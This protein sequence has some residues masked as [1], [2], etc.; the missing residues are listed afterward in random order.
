MEFVGFFSL[1]CMKLLGMC[2][3]LA[4]KQEDNTKLGYRL[5][6][7]LQNSLEGTVNPEDK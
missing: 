4:K 6:R 2:R 5:R 1:T 7:H 3:I